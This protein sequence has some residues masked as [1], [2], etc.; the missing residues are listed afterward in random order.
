MNE[1]QK[2]GDNISANI[3]GGVSGQV[4][5]GKQISQDQTITSV[6]Q[7]EVTED[8]LAVLRRLLANVKGQVESEAPPEKKEAALQRVVELEEA[9]TA[10]QP[11]LD[12][13]AYVKK[14]FIKNLPSL[15]GA[16]TGVVIHPIVGKLVGAAG[17]ALA[18]E[19]R[20]RFGAD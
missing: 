10:K 8:D 17:D 3:S 18:D 11:D 2:A 12:T 6:P 19:F 5:V 4:A 20:D 13:M 15:S 9:V 1:E 16:V 14:W 7:P